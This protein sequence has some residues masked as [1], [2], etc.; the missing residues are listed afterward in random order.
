MGTVQARGDGDTQAGYQLRVRADDERD[1]IVYD[2]GFV[3]DTSMTSHQYE[4]G[5][6]DEIDDV[7]GMQRYSMPFKPGGHYHWHLRVQDSTGVWSAWSANAEG[8][9]QDFVVAEAAK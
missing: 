4:A 9:F 7:T 8:K 3:G 2:T 1:R 5:A 6:N